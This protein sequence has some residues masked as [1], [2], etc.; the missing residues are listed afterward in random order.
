[1]YKSRENFNILSFDQLKKMPTHRLL[2]HLKSVNAVIS[3]IHNYAGPRCCEICHD[4]I[5][6]DWENDVKIPVRKYVDY[7][8]V[9]KSVLATRENIKTT[10]RL[11]TFRRTKRRERVGFKY[12]ITRGRKICT[13]CNRPK[14]K[15]KRHF[16]NEYV[17]DGSKK[18]KRAM[19]CY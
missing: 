1:M 5:G 2:G 7:K 3:S 14:N 4:Y 16:P 10:K 18:N 11:P 12:E 9:V 19:I 13:I 6:D 8:T 17:V 15:C